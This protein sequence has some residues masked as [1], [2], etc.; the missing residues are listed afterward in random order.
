MTSYLLSTR[1][2]TYP[3]NMAAAYTIHTT[4]MN[5]ATAKNT[6]PHRVR[7]YTVTVVSLK[8][9]DRYSPTAMYQAMV[10]MS[11]NMYYIQTAT[12]RKPVRT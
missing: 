2:L 6:W 7:K 1:C 3:R 9:P 11:Y 12:V 4:S 5:M 10:Y 8:N